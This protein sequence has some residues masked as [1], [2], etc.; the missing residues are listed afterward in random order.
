MM[1]VWIYMGTI[2]IFLVGV[3]VYYMGC[4]SAGSAMV[5]IAGVIA[6]AQMIKEE[7][8]SEKRRDKKCMK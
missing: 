5:F 6:A 1:H 3:A 4:T 2:S 8:V 7:V